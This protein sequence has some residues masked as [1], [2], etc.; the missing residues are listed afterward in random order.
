MARRGAGRLGSLGNLRLQRLRMRPP[1]DDRVFLLFLLGAE[2]VLLLFD[3][4]YPFA[5][6]RQLAFSRLQGIQP[7]STVAPDV[8]D[9]SEQ[10]LSLLANRRD[11]LILLGQQRLKLRDLCRKF[12][13]GFV[14]GSAGGMKVHPLPP[15]P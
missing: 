2:V 8:G 14:S 7:G 9:L 11:P 12:K 15:I 6:H 1:S 4:I 10:A 13:L 3:A 5:R